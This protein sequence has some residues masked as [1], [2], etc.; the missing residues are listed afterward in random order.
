M[1]RRRRIV[2]SFDDEP[3]LDV[4]EFQLVAVAQHGGTLD[5]LALHTRTVLAIEI[6]DGGLV[7]IDDDARVAAGD[8]RIVDADGAT[9]LATDRV[10]AGTEDEPA[11]A[12]AQ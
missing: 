7:V 11:M 2:R 10:D 3:A 1:R 8:T 9:G 5:R 12:N 4:S 6:L